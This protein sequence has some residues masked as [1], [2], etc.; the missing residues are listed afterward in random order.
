MIIRNVASTS[1]GFESNIL[2]DLFEKKIN[3]NNEVH[4]YLDVYG[5]AYEYRRYGLENLQEILENRIYL[6]E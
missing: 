1:S 4:F 6:K 2:D 3:F 5:N